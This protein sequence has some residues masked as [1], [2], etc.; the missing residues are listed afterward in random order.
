MN[1]IK[2]LHI[3]SP[4]QFNV[5]GTWAGAITAIQMLGVNI[6]PGAKWGFNDPVVGHFS[7]LGQSYAAVV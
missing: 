6:A 5:L 2:S 1:F 7:K 4:H 3:R